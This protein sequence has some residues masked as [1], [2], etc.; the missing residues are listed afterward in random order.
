MLRD[1]YVEPQPGRVKVKGA[2]T[3]LL[4]AD[5]PDSN[6]WNGGHSDKLR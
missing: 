3:T 4:P 1:D 2:V 6:W 5:S